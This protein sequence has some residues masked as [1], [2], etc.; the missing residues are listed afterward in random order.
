MQNAAETG[1]YLKKQLVNLKADHPI[2]GDV[3]GIGLF[4]A[5]EFVSDQKT[6]VRFGPEDRMAARM[7]EKLRNHGLILNSRGDILH[8]GPPLC[9]TSKDVDQIVHAVDLSLWEI[10]GELGIARKP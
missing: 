9:V 2:V 10:E 5:L 7:T 3:R 8:I 6:R 4:V 1:A